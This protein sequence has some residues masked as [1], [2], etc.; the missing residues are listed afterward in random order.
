MAPLR[1]RARHMSP[2]HGHYHP[3]GW[4]V[5]VWRLV[6]LVTLVRLVGLVTLVR[7]MR[8]MRLVGLVRG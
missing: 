3:L 2:T 1:P 6:T 7:R 8:L 4:A 5:L